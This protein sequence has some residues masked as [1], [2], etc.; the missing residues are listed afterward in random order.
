M[1][2]PWTPLLDFHL[3]EGFRV[4]WNSIRDLAKLTGR[5]PGAVRNR[6]LRLRK[7]GLVGCRHEK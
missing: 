2:K 5:S 3:A 1:G 4:D 6:L 7:K